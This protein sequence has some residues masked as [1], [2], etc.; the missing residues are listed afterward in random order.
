MIVGES[1]PVVLMCICLA[2]CLFV[3]QSVCALSYATE[4]KRKQND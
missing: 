1:L 2:V 3:C 4:V